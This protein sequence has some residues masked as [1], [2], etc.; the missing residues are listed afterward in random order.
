MPNGNTCPQCGA[1][2][3]SHV[4]WCYKCSHRVAGTHGPRNW[5]IGIIVVSGVMLFG[6]L[7]DLANLLLSPNGDLFGELPY[8]V[9]RTAV[10]L[11]LVAWS[12]FALSARSSVPGWRKAR[13]FRASLELVLGCAATL[14]AVSRILS[15]NALSSADGISLVALTVSGVVLLTVGSRALAA[16]P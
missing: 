16:S 10:L 1:V 2:I 5:L 11:S 7:S 13:V 12:G 4:H 3:P 14:V 9:G 15:A 8:S 6:S